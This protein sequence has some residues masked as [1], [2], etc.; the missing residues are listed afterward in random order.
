MFHNHNF[1]DMLRFAIPLVFISIAALGQPQSNPASSQEA[2]PTRYFKHFSE[3]DKNST[4]PENVKTV[5][6]IPDKESN[7]PYGFFSYDKNG[8]LTES[9]FKY[10]S[11]SFRKKFKA[12]W[13]GDQQQ[14]Q[15]S[16]SLHRNVNRRSLDSI[17]FKYKDGKLYERRQ[18]FFTPEEIVLDASFYKDGKL[19]LR[20]K[21]SNKPS[22]DQVFTPMGIDTIHYGKDDQV[23]KR[24]Y[25]KIEGKETDCIYHVMKYTESGK[26]KD[27]KL[28]T[29]SGEKL[30]T[31][32]MK[33]DE[34]DSLV[35]LRTKVFDQKGK[36]VQSR[37]LKSTYDK[38]G[39]LLADS[40]WFDRRIS[41]TYGLN[42]KRKQE[43]FVVYD[44]QGQPF[45]ITQYHYDKK[46]KTL[47]SVLLHS[48]IASQ[49]K[50]KER[51]IDYRTKSGQLTKRERLVAGKLEE[52]EHYKYDENGYLIALESKN[53]E[54]KI[55]E[56]QF[57]K[58][59]FH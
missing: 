24:V 45:M 19:A 27:R 15:T 35:D 49:V 29:S 18:Y 39:V 7:K 40:N 46:K 52:I 20:R 22:K 26:L 12:E 13:K 30:R 31:L 47:T 28:L 58:Y 33:Y 9:W 36:V 53:A 21:Y 1:D 10:A 38:K 16:R 44:S 14:W 23:V 6:M 59:T 43:T 51:I 11:G 41:H 48:S 3:L 55:L 57:I 42:K 4:I 34:R 54:G 5:T 8:H 37:I 25:C 2:Q 50:E 56:R 32:E 17:S